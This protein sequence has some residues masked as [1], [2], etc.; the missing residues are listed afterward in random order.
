[1]SASVGKLKADQI[2]WILRDEAVQGVRRN[3]T[4][5]CGKF[6]GGGMGSGPE[7]EAEL[8]LMPKPACSLPELP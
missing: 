8:L 4:S 5:D 2:R 3:Y 1:M 7:A 6:D